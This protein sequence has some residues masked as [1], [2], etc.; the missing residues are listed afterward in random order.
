MNADWVVIELSSG[1]DMAGLVMESPDKV[2]V[3][4]SEEEA[5]KFIHTNCQKAIPRPATD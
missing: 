1:I 5:K 3:F 2:M 4:P